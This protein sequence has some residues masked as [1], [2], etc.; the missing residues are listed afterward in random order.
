MKFPGT[1]TGNPLEEW[2]Y[3]LIHDN[4][5]FADYFKSNGT[6]QLRRLD[7]KQDPRLSLELDGILFLDNTA[8]IFEITSQNSNLKNKIGKFARNCNHFTTSSH[9][10]LR[11][12][13]KLFNVPDDQLDVFEEIQNWKFVYINTSPNA[14]TSKLSRADISDFPAI[15]NELYIFN[16]THMDYVTALSNLIGRFAK[17]EFLSSFEV[18]ASELGEV[19]ASFQKSGPCAAGK[20]ITTDSTKA[21][22]VL[23]KFTVDNLIKFARV[24]R[25]EGVPLTFESSGDTQYQRLLSKK[26]L[27]TIA[28]EY[29]KNNRLVS[30][31]NTITIVLNNACEI[32]RGEDV[33]TLTIPKS[34]GAMDII[35]GQHRLYAYANENI[36]DAVREHGEI[37]ATCIKFRDV[38]DSWLFRSMGATDFGVWVPL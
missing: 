28:T 29:I 17:Y 37:L 18:P 23:I 24:S 8:V 35:D 15:Q 36:S 19:G 7:P 20:I 34:F 16:A 27:D 13:F 38:E 10:S 33:A 9:L 21:D 30:F 3:I 26:K 22:I 31:P 2:L 25:Y 12:K 14:R 6:I 5:G 1:L 4:L 11:E 32:N